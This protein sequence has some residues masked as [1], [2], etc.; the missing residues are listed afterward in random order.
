MY[1]VSPVWKLGVPIL[2]Y[3][4][5]FIYRYITKMVYRYLYRQ[6]KFAYIEI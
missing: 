3:V 4:S 5:I 6:G 2:K 1:D